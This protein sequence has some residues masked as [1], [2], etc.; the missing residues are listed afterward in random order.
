MG[1]LD[2]DLFET[3][4]LY[5]EKDMCI[6]VYCIYALGRTIQVRSLSAAAVSSISCPP[7]ANPLHSVQVTVPEY[8]GP[9]LGPRMSQP[10]RRVFT[11]EQ[12]LEGRRMSGM[13]QISA[14]S[15]D[16]MQRTHIDTIPFGADM[17]SR[18]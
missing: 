11:E 8:S 9:T 12:Q 15:M 2:H 17:E 6:V 10:N 16:I 4:D 5:D 13:T 1:V 3:V 14:G 7:E 18:K